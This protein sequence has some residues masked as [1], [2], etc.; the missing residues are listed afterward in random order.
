MKI[1]VIG[2][3]LS[4]IA[5]S[6]KLLSLTDD[7]CLEIH[8]FEKQPELGGL[9]K[10]V[11]F[12]GYGFDFGPHNFHSKIGSFHEDLVSLLGSAYQKRS[13]SSQ[14]VFR[15]KFIPYP[16]TGINILK[17]IRPWTS[18]LCFGSFLYSRIKSLFVPWDDI[19]FKSFITNRFG[20]R[21]FQ[22]Y[23]GPFTKKVWGIDASEL[24]A[25]FGRERIGV[26][27]LWDLFKRTFLNI[28]P[29]ASS[30]TQEDPFARTQ[31]YYPEK[32]CEQFINSLLADCKADSRFHIHT[33]SEIIDIDS[34]SLSVITPEDVVKVDYC[35]SSMPLTNLADMLDI[36]HSKLQFTHMKFLLLMLDRQSVFNKSPW[37][38]F[39]DSAVLFNR[40]SEPKKSSKYMVPEG[41]T[42]LC[43]EF[44]STGND[45]IWKMDDESIAK[46]GIE[47][48]EK[49]NLITDKEVID[50]KV[51]SAN[52]TH[53]VKTIGYK[54]TINEIHKQINQISGIFTFGRFGTF[55]HMNM[56]HCFVEAEKLACSFLE[57]ILESAAD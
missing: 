34:H 40:V 6:R 24:S 21:L 27:N 41:K 50:W 45:S 3:G 37:I 19:S 29:T 10:T 15:N 31:W 32:G 13:F 26:Y 46:V 36:D 22:I 17:S 35:F 52:P 39:Q 42:S 2:G 33:N 20:N 23:F 11:W 55:S 4:G 1:A 38:Y 18:A 49:Y 44:T 9:C 5:F 8:L 51:I 43:L 53:P 48:L 7:D 25:D 54:Q 47:G 57:N 30:T 16:M 56:D 28:R 12:D 14:I